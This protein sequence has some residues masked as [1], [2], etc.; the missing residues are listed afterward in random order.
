[1]EAG[2]VRAK[3][4]FTKTEFAVTCGISLSAVSHALSQGRLV[5]T[6]KGNIDIRRKVNRLFLEMHLQEKPHAPD[7][8]P[9]SPKPSIH[10]EKPGSKPSGGNGQGIT[11][12]IRRLLAEICLKEEQAETHR[13]RRLERMGSLVQRTIVEQR[14][15]V[16]GNEIKSRLLD[17]PARIF[18]QIAALVK[19]GRDEEALRCFEHEISE[20]I[21]RIKEKAIS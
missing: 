14:L 9:V 5:A 11:L 2:K 17:L 7:P 15:A 8:A 18:P 21:Q 16:L 10:V 12:N 20:A 13:Q 1:M 6:S 4:I 19:S 3:V